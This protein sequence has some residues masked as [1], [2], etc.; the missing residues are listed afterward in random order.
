MTI[1]ITEWRTKYIREANEKDNASS[2]I[3][4]D[5]LLNYETVKYYGNEEFEVNRFKKSIEECVF[6]PDSPKTLPI[7]DIK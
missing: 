7:S 6:H 5:S 1:S 2:A 3:A 4:T